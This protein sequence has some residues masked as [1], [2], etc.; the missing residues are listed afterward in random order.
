[1]DQLLIYLEDAQKLIIILVES[2]YQ[3]EQN[4]K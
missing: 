4:F 3:K 2:Q 1:M